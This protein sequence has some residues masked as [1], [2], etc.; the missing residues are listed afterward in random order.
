MLLA[1]YQ[2]GIAFAKVSITRSQLIDI[3]RFREVDKENG[4]VDLPVMMLKKMRDASARDCCIPLEFLL[5]N[6][7]HRV[8]QTA[9]KLMRRNSYTP[10]RGV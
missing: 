5:T 3:D 9:L 1:T 6:E 2:A 10:L 4:M 7:Y 8:R